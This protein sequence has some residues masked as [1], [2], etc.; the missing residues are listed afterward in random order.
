MTAAPLPDT[1]L[2]QHVAIVGKTGAGKTYL[3]KGLVERL[4]DAGRRVCIVDPTGA[5]WGVRSSTD[6]RRA[7]Y[8]VVVLGGDHADI[9][10]G[11]R[12][13]AAVAGL[14][15]ERNLPCI[16]DL[17][18]FLIGAR[19]RF[20]E[21]FAAELYRR[22]RTPLHLILDEADEMAP[23][24]PLPETKRMLHQIDRI[25]R[26]GRI[27]GFRVVLITQRPA[28][29]HKNVLTQANTLIAMRLLAP[30]DRKA[31]E[32]WIKGQGDLK[33]GARVLATLAE[34]KRGEGW[35]WAPEIG[36]LERRTFPAIATYD[37]SRAPDDGAAPA[38]AKLAD[39]DVSALRSSLDEAVKEAAANDPKL[40]RQRVAE[41][42]RAA[43][44][45]GGAGV[46]A[47]RMK[48]WLAETP[49]R[50]ANI[51]FTAGA[52]RTIANL[53]EDIERRTSEA[54]KMETRTWYKGIEERLSKIGAQLNA[55]CGELCQQNRETANA[56]LIV[57]VPAQSSRSPSATASMPRPPSPAARSVERTDGYPLPLAG[58]KFLT[59]LAQQ[60]RQ[61]T[62][63]QVAIFAG[64]SVKSGH[65]D[66][67]LGMLRA[68]G[69]AEGG[70]EAIRITTEGRHALGDFEALPTGEDLRRYWL[71][72]V[73]RAGAAFLDILFDI[74]PKTI[75]R[76][77][78]AA[79]AGYSPTSGHVDN[80][81]G[82][83]RTLALAEGRNH[84]IKASD[85]LFEASP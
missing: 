40:L 38:P 67:T 58:R 66:N 11:E 73:D 56:Q 35:V 46:D 25:V 78:L 3:A 81:L 7:G 85:R 36:L 12:S 68:R 82:R 9:P 44:R 65:V 1:V 75:P 26:R 42:E 4:L 52:E 53:V 51:A 8:P 39:V 50:Q 16:V 47:E 34:L 74:Y 48:A 10:I 18:E 41:L 76:D 31:V 15:A 54:A 80:V 13:G 6:G 30:Q 21:E 24:N 20:V 49:R 61:L 69:W 28:V 72:R 29:L 2:A 33:L 84:A 57:R 22:N 17:S 77:E 27:K 32:E 59:V 23:Q 79:H 19:H 55:V 60:D 5:W 62:R 83:L 45:K 37:S 71:G 64:Y 14:V 70:N 43:Q 63:S